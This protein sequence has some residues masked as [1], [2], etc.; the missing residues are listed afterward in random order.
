MNKRIEKKNNFIKSNK[1]I[2]NHSLGQHFLIDKNITKKI[3]GLA[4]NLKDKYV[5][6]VGPGTGNLTKEILN[7]NAKKVFTIERDKRFSNY[8]EDLKDSNQNLEIIYDDALKF[9]E[10]KII[11]NQTIVI[12]NLP[13]NIS[14]QLLVKWIISNLQ[15]K[16]L[17][18]MFQK[19]VAQRINAERANKNY[20]RLSVL[21]QW[22]YISKIVMNISSSSFIP[23]PKVD[24]SIIHLIKRDKEIAPAPTR[25]FLYILQHSFRHRRKM[26]K[27]NLRYIHPDYDKIL[28]QAK[29]EG[30]RRAEDISIKEFC[31]LASIYSKLI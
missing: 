14:T 29:I 26:I 8:L 27:N 10:S 19:E 11:N 7:A 9:D 31:N 5:Y 3:V 18:L 1:P 25:E 21:V 22:K 30:H 24:S 17:I 12:S 28:S 20:G 6:E 23:K 2:A 16:E 4:G 15:F 13:Y